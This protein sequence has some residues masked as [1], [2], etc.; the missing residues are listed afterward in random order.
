MPHEVRLPG[1]SPTVGYA[2]DAGAREGEEV[3]VSST[4]FTSSEDGEI[5]VTR[6][7]GIAQELLSALPE[8]ARLQPSQVD[9]LVGIYRKDMTATVYL[10]EC[11]IRAQVRSARTIDAGELVTEDD[12]ADIASASFVVRKTGEE[13]VFPPDAGLVVVFSSGWRKGLFFDQAPLLPDG[14]ERDYDVGKALGSFLARLDNAPI[15]SMDRETWDFMIG[16]G[17]FPFI[18]LPRRISRSLVGFARSE[19]DLDVVLPEVVEAVGTAVPGFRESWGQAELFAPHRDLLLRA[20]E[21]FEA[22]DYLSC[23]ALVH[24]R[25]EGILR[26]IHEALGETGRPGQRALARMGTEGRREVLHEN[27]Y[28]LPDG[29]RRFLEEAYFA[30]FEPGKPATLSRNSVGH[31]VAS[32][33]EFGEKGACLSL[34]IVHQ[35]FYYLPKT[36]MVEEPASDADGAPARED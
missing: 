10:N 29:F 8:K 14:K 9:H 6:L 27:S 12:I 11:F 5:F 18:G 1:E 22:G 21:R 25:I 32:Q 19:I 24:S 33:E 26:S 36:E 30:D 16:R 7:E 2:V 3:R 17:W 28:L 15:A 35:L 13:V 23:T 34:L 4:E 31:G 20:L